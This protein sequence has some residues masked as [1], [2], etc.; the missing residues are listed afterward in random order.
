[1]KK[2]SMLI[3]TFLILA[4]F[5]TNAF[6]STV[7]DPVTIEVTTKYTSADDALQ[8]A[9][10]AL[11]KEKFIST[12]GVQKIGFTATRTTNAKA[13]YYVA[14]VA[15]KLEKGKIKITISFVKVGTGLLRLQKVADAVKENLE[16]SSV[17]N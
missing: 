15:A 11:L 16:K 10:T 8:A 13:D 5:F 6:S 17:Q 3:P 1:M 14:D 12:Q 2:L 7:K 4:G 9:K